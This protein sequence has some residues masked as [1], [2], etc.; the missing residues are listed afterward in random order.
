MG[1][2]QGAT[3]KRTATRE[4]VMWHATGQHRVASILN[5]GLMP[6]LSQTAR[7][8]IWLFTRGRRDWGRE[9]VRQRHGYT[10]VAL[11]RVLVPRSWLKR[12]RKGLWSCERWIGPERILAVRPAPFCD[13]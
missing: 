4:V 6:E 11:V 5:N 13:N 2:I 9:H 8:E 1:I 7:P 12:R 10:A 3:A